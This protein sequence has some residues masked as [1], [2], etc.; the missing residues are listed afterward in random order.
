MIPEK[1]YI[2][3]STLNF[4]N[5]TSSESI[6]PASFYIQRGFGYKRFEKVGPNPL[7]N[8]ILIYTEFPMFEIPDNE[9]ENYP[10]VIEIDSRYVNE[11][12]IREN[13]GNY[14]VDETIYLNPFTTR[15]IFRNNQELTSTI[16][17]SEPAIETKMVSLYK[18]CLTIFKS[19]KYLKS[20]NW[21]KT[22]LE[23]SRNDISSYI[24]KDRRINKLK[25][26]LYGY[27]IASNRMLSPDVVFLKK[28]VRN[29]KN[30][31]SAIITSPDGRATY[32]QEEQ[33]KT[34]Y[35]LIK[36]GEIPAIR[37][38]SQWRI[39]KEALEKMISD[40][41]NRNKKEE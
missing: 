34:L 8:R 38:G 36:R 37:L 41:N 7:N 21:V 11:D 25:G 31:L 27:L 16:S 1:L 2:P 15:F 29:L 24:S 3:T 13:N 14:Y 9:L 5:I 19:E 35:K 26:L 28:L 6:S 39:P 30:T 4:N 18:N 23:D 10:M 12:I 20:F 32:A 17:K 33:L 40:T 22:E